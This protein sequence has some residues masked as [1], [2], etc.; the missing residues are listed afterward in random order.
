MRMRILGVIEIQVQKE[1]GRCPGEGTETITPKHAGA[2]IGERHASGRVGVCVPRSDGL[3]PSNT[4]RFH[5]TTLHDGQRPSLLGQTHLSRVSRTQTFAGVLRGTRSTAG[6]TPTLP[7][8][9]SLPQFS[10]RRRA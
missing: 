10:Q 9:R 8:A 6:G 1:K 5:A 7:E 3:W 2:R 4:H